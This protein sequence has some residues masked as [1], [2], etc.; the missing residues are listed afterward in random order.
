MKVSMIFIF[1]GVCTVAFSQQDSSK[2]DL[3]PVFRTVITKKITY[4]V[5]A[6]EA[7]AYAK[8]YAGFRINSRGH[9]QDIVILNP[10]KVGYEFD[11]H[12][13]KQLKRL[14]PLS[15]KLEGLYVLPINFYIKS[16][17]KGNEVFFISNSLP[18][19]YY[20]GRTLLSELRVTN[21]ISV[22]VKKQSVLSPGGQLMIIN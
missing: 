10:V 15:P 9:I 13:I 20:A 19:F 4:P 3:D 6:I 5:Q 18:S 17:T 21:S 16:Y 2:L 7:G 8:I 14:P 11:T 22:F 1:L 12:V